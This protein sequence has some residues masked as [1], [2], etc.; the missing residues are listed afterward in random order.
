M[1]ITFK[2][3]SMRNFLSYG[4]NTTVVEFTNVGT[5]LIMGE[6]LDDTTE[7]VGGNGT[8][9]AQPLHCKVKTPIGWTT[10]GECKVG[11]IV[12]TPNGK[13]ANIIGVYPQGIRPTYKITFSDGRTTEA[14][15]DHLWEVFSHRWD[16]SGKRGTRTLTTKQIIPLIEEWKNKNPRYSIF[17]PKIQPDKTTPPSDFMIHPY[18]LGSLLGDGC[19]SGGYILFTSADSHSIDRIESLLL[20]HKQHLVQYGKKSPNYDWI[21]V[22][23]IKG[24]HNLLSIRRQLSQLG[25]LHTKSSTKFIPTEYLINSNYDQKL[26][27]LQGLM[28]TDGTVGK[29]KNISFS[30]SSN[31][32]AQDVQYLI[33]SIGGTAKISKRLPFYKN[34]NSE[35]VE[36]QLSYEVS[37]QVPNPHILFTLP[38]KL[39]KLSIGHTQYANSG[40][41]IDMVEY[42]GEKETQCIMIDSP[43][44]LYITDDFIVTHN[45]T[46]LNALVYTLFD[47]PVSNISKDKLVNNINNKN[48]EV[49]VE[50]DIGD[51]VYLI[52]RERKS[53]N[54]NNVYFYINGE[55]KTLDSVTNTN[56]YIE[57]VIGISYDLFVRIV[58]FS[59]TL[60][61]FLDLPKAE[62]AGMFERLV[63]LTVLAD[64]A[65]ALKELIK[66][67]ENSL[68]IKKTRLDLIQQE[69]IRHNS[70]I[71]NTKTRISN[72]EDTTKNKITELQ[73]QLSKIKGVDLEKQ[74][75]IHDK[76]TEVNL[77]LV[78][79]IGQFDKLENSI[80][81]NKAQITKYTKELEQL[82]SH[83]CP[84]CLQDYNDVETKLNELSSSVSTLTNT[85]EQL[86]IELS[87]VDSAIEALENIQNNLKPQLTSPNIKDLLKIQNQSSAIE[88][89]IDTLLSSTNPHTEALDELINIKLDSIDFSEVNILTKEV[90][91]QKLLLKLLTKRDSFVRKML[92]NKYIPYLNTRL[93][94]YLSEMLLR[95]TVEF[96]HEMTANISQFGNT[97]DFGNLSAGQKARVNLALSLSFSDVLQRLHTKVNIWMLDEVLDVGLDAVGI[98]AAAKV[99]KR[100]AK[101]EEL[102]TYIISH[103]EEA[104]HIFDN[105]LTIQMKQGFSY[106]P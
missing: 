10:I 92:L 62:Q 54:G 40:L 93:Q 51:D 22:N 17:V 21:L 71:T 14:D 64:K 27:L 50:F 19:M 44:H 23:N 6:N 5:T 103:R 60:N 86:L 90:E 49:S 16:Q 3:V 81:S 29:T 59:A 36:G 96:T 48:M 89:N 31:Q 83:K 37:I 98:Q 88:A 63:G 65:V 34:Q 73:A 45:T 66:D 43:E 100:R 69:H 11:D 84:Y 15:E 47:K 30:S 8:G 13:T 28:D 20:P 82:Q 39:E 99:I 55:D 79:D 91:H 101:E 56:K 105:T 70:Q 76:L 32:L 68:K 95:H 41:R 26:E 87:E 78:V 25:I 75:E 80:K 102:S 104:R 12:S 18:L 72:W 42:L 4:N 67:T 2:T 85:N 52:K 61:P 57:E 1:N 9:K 53:K 33:R 35:R 7:G 94:Y 106:I 58:V 24:S 74:Q 38:R 77:Q 97:L 46:I